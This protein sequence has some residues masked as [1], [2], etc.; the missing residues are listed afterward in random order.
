MMGPH[1]SRYI[2]VPML[3]GTV[4][5]GSCQSSPTA[6]AVHVETAAHVAL[7]VPDVADVT[8]MARAMLPAGSNSAPT[9]YSS[10]PLMA[11]CA[12]RSIT[13]IPRRL[14]NSLARTE[15]C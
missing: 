11:Y 2:P 6:P 14:R 10:L 7:T 3:L 1:L 12:R 5:L 8:Y 9:I 13:R 4:L 15:S